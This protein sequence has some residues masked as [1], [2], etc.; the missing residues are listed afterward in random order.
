MLLKPFD[1]LALY[2]SAICSTNF[3]PKK[4]YFFKLVNFK[5]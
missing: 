1:I 2:N 5:L 4:N 3:V